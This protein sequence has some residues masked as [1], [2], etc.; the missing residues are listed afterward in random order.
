MADN[1]IETRVTDLEK[2]QVVQDAKFEAFMQEM[3]DFKTEMRDRDN[4]RAA[5]I[6]DL[7]KEMRDRDE[8]RAAEVA[9]LRQETNQKVDQLSRD[10]KDI[11]REVRTIFIGFAAIVVALV[12]TLFN[13]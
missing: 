7:R 3:R 2:K 8:Q 12:I 9:E 13:K 6:R 1:N 11:G 10:I 5:E 4:Q